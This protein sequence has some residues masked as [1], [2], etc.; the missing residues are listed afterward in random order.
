MKRWGTADRLLIEA[1]AL[2]RIE[3]LAR[4]APERMGEAR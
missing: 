2:A 3:E 4:P 1:A